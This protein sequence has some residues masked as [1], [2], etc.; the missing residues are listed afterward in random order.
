M[1]AVPPLDDEL[2]PLEGCRALAALEEVDEVDVVDSPDEV[3]VLDELDAVAPEAEVEDEV[4]PGIVAALTALNAA[5]PAT[6]T[7]AAP[8]VSRWSRRRAAS[9]A[10]MRRSVLCVRSM[11][12]SLDPSAVP[13][14]G[15][16]L[17]VPGKAR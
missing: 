12:G 5:T 17:E 15:N 4:V 8:T 11:V 14:V 2:T 13:N 6:P 10:R 16:G 1:T 9:R 7:S 3:E